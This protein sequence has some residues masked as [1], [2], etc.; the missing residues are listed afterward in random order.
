MINTP[1]ENMYLVAPTAMLDV[2]LPLESFKKV[3]D[4]GIETGE[5]HSIVSYL[6][7]LNHTVERYNNDKTMFIKGFNWTIDT[8]DEVR[9]KCVAFGL[10]YKVNLFILNRD[11]IGELM[12]VE[13]WKQL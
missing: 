6:A 9:E 11:Q 10:E 8:I 13:S 3:D 4:E 5:Y 12:E 2:E 7:S 1:Q